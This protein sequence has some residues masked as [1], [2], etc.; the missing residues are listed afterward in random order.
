MPNVVS[1]KLHDLHRASGVDDARL[2][3]RRV[4]VELTFVEQ[5]VV[6]DV[7]TNC[8]RQLVWIVLNHGEMLRK[9]CTY[10]D[11]LSC[12]FDP[13]NRPNVLLP[14][15]RRRKRGTRVEDACTAVPD[16]VVRREFDVP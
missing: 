6:D 10:P 3:E 14:L 5:E 9:L 13:R 12:R 1:R 15:I 7:L 4:V 16:H 11:H 2:E 8:R